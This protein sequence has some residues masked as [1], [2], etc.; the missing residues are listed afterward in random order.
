MHAC[1]PASDW[2]QIQS[3]R[4]GA[5]YIIC[6]CCLGKGS[7][8]SEKE[9][10]RNERHF[11]I[12][13]SADALVEAHFPLSNP[14]T[15]SNHTQCDLSGD[16]PHLQRPRSQW[17]IAA[18]TS[19]TFVQLAAHADFNAHMSEPDSTAASDHSSAASSTD[20][21]PPTSSAAES[22][23]GDKRAAVGLDQCNADD[24][25]DDGV[26]HQ[27]MSAPGLVGST[28]AASASATTASE[29]SRAAG[30]P[31]YWA[32][33]KALLEMDRSAAALEFVGARAASTSDSSGDNR[34]ASAYRVALVKM[35]PPS[36]SVKND[37]L[38][39][40][41]RAQFA[42]LQTAEAARQAAACTEEAY[43]GVLS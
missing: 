15:D 22:K 8:R 40:V 14:Q 29:L 1:G 34:D 38:L 33:C 25:E 13:P 20:S 17:G 32:A 26:D 4:R 35:Q 16:G 21:M 23:C 27:S 12:S 6:P 11:E 31:R 41:T 2:A 5:T 43:F 3:L 18:L 39:G 19:D 36:A 37:V 7:T 42:R 24:S 30:L 10:K 28:S 9:L